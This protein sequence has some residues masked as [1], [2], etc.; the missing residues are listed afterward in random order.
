MTNELADTLLAFKEFE[1]PRD[2][3]GENPF[4]LGCRLSQPATPEEIADSWDAGRVP[5]ELTCEWEVSRESRLFEDVDYGQWGLV[6]LSPSDA[7][8]RT[9]EQQELRRDDVLDDVVVGEFLGDQDLLLLSPADGFVRVSRPLDARSDWPVV[10]MTLD[11]FLS[12]YLQARGN[13]YWE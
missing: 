7:W 8:A 13:K 3:V 4:R 5:Q 9:V 10:G 11:D 1:Q 12:Q 6:L 2:G